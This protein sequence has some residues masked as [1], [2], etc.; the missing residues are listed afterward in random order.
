MQMDGRRG[1]GGKWEGRGAEDGGGGGGKG[2]ATVAATAG[3]DGK[4]A[5]RCRIM[6]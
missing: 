1:R 2:G 5:G 6:D 3:S 4:G